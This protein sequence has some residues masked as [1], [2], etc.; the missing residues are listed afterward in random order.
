MG[1]ACHAALE[2]TE[3]EAA[4]GRNYILT[5]QSP[6]IVNNFLPTLLNITI[7]GKSIAN[8]DPGK[9]ANFL[10]LEPKKGLSVLDI[11]VSA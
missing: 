4:L 11:K 8:L 5:I 1:A 7:H 6:V 3:R 9:S 10:R 2:D